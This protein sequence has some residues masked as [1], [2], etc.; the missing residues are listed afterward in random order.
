LQQ[1][2]SIKANRGHAERTLIYL[3]DKML[4][5]NQKEQEDTEDLPEY[6]RKGAMVLLVASQH[7]AKANQF[8][9]QYAEILHKNWPAY[10]FE[11]EFE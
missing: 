6:D 9:Q 2:A 4:R 1:N 11:F 5:R 8:S 10:R 3:A 7:E